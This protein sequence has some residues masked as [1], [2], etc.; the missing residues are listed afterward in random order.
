MLVPDKNMGIVVMSSLYL[1]SSIVGV[2][3]D[4][5]GGSAVTEYSDHE[6][7]R[8]KYQDFDVCLHL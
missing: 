3:E 8:K 6:K 2:F 1:A 5:T 7:Y 4:R